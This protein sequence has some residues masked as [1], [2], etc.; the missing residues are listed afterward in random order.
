MPHAG[1]VII[2]S[3]VVQC[4]L[5]IKSVWQQLSVLAMW[6]DALQASYLH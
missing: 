3:S 5:H 4:K 2:A 1:Q 6:Q